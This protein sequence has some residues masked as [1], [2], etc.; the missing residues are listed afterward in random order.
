VR[1]QVRLRLKRRS[2][3]TTLQAIIVCL[4]DF[5][6]PESLSKQSW[7]GS[8]FL[9]PVGQALPLGR[10]HTMEKR[11]GEDCRMRSHLDTGSV[12]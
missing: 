6:I 10:Q 3:S 7:M 2:D 4:T 11:E 9:L 5:V 12:G 1:N 8:A